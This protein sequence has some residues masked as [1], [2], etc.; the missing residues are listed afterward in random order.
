MLVIGI[1]PGMT[2]GIAALDT[3]SGDIDIIDMPVL[4]NTKG[5]LVLDY[6]GLHKL[7]TL[8]HDSKITAYIEQVG[9][10]PGQGVSSTFRFG[11]GYGALQMAVVAQGFPLIFITPAKWKAYFGLNRDKGL[12]RSLASRRFPAAADRF[13][14]V[15]HDG[16][17]EAALIALYGAEQL[18]GRKL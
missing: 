2:G 11:E 14:L 3:E 18:L 16:R 9:S 1:D 7:L 6:H 12:S 8:T 13:T 17:A 5:K 15:K 4:P 10:M